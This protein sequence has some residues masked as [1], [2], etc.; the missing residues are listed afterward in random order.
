MRNLKSTLAVS[1]ALFVLAAPFAAAQEEKKPE[2]HT[3]AAG[4]LKV[5]VSLDGV[6]EAEQ[7][8]EVILRPEEW[9]GLVVDK[10]VPQ[11]TKV[12]AGDPVLWLETDK[13]ADA[14]RD[15]E[16]ALELG[17]LSLAGAELEL[18][19]LEASVPLDLRAAERSHEEAQKSLE[20]YV[21]VDEE[22][23]RRSAEESFKSS[24]YNLEYSQEE[25][26]QLE[27]MYKA[28]DLTEQTEEIIL[29][30]A[31]RDVDRAK[32]FLEGARIRFDRQIN[33]EI[34]RQREVVQDAAERASLSLQKAQATL[35][36]S[37]EQKRI[38]F[39]KLQKGQADLEKKFA[40][41]QTDLE[42]LTVKSPAAGIVYYGQCDKGAWPTSSTVA[43]QLRK[44][45]SVAPNQI[46]MTI[47]GEGPAF[48]R[49][50]VPE[51]DLRWMKPG[52]EGTVTPA[53]FPDA[54]LPARLAAIDP[55]PLGGSKF[56]GKVAFKLEKGEV[57]LVPGMSCSVK[58]TAYYKADALTVPTSAVFSEELD[59]T[60]KYVYVAKDEGA[61]EKRTV[62]A[63]QASGDKTE[64]VSGLAAGDKVLLKKPE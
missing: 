4:P 61:P 20:H 23:S 55:I 17:K 26:N 48:V 47:V 46:V 38:D 6:F 34:P 43:K 21:K 60:Q 9:S 14:I 37:L 62:K 13:L 54:R 16:F 10:A 39:K 56:D 2:T 45:G 42:L 31:Q 22:M 28:D 57:P 8:T 12:A 15:T 27:Q 50:E 33:E 49:V 52:L 64:I 59:D 3:V 24:E 5:S 40:D 7:M 44:G 35:P 32:F 63:G 25:L 41:L 18:A 51:K 11:G 29:K 53:A 30:R 19:N 36:R 1:T 58:L